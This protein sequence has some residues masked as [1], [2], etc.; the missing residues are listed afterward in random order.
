MVISFR[1]FKKTNVTQLL[2]S[3]LYTFP[4]YKVESSLLSV[5]DHLYNEDHHERG[6]AVT[7]HAL[8]KR[9]KRILGQPMDRDPET[10]TYDTATD[11]YPEKIL[12]CLSFILFSWMSLY[13]SQ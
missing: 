7:L 12:C 3:L 6:M 4:K 10:E 5:I 11:N 2:E 1:I 8:T 13:Y 9:T